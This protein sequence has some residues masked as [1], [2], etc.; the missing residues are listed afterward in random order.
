MLNSTSEILTDQNR[1]TDEMTYGFS[2]GDILYSTM[3][4]LME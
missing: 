1:T 2:V 3:E 4:I